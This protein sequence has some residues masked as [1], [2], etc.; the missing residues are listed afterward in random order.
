MTW[1]S[2]VGAHH[3][4]GELFQH[5]G[6]RIGAQSICDCSF[7][8]TD[9]PVSCGQFDDDGTLRSATDVEDA[10]VVDREHG[11]GFLCSSEGC[12]SHK[13]LASISEGRREDHQAVFAVA[14]PSRL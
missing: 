3:A 4:W 10:K 8:V 5:A 1:V 13:R 2:R 7:A 9:D 11:C 6:G 14:R 12:W